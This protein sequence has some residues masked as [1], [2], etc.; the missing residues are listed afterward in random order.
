MSNEPLPTISYLRFSRP[1][2]MRSDS[3]RRQFDASGKGAAK[4]GLTITDSLTLKP[5]PAAMRPQKAR[6][7]RRASAGTRSPNN[8]VYDT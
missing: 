6:P 8:P 3:L 1:G 4:S 2:Q 5:R 7:F